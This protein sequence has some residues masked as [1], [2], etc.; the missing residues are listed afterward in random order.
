MLSQY[1]TKNP[2]YY[3]NPRLDIA[4]LLPES[5]EKVL[6]IGCGDGAT[7]AWL[8]A[9]NKCKYAAGVEYFPDAA[10][11]ARV[12]CDELYMGPVE[13]HIFQFS[14]ESFDLVLCLDVLEHLQDPWAV[15]NEIQ[16]VLRPGG[17][18]ICSL[19]NVRHKSVLLPLIFKNQWRYQESGIMDMTHLRFF[20][21][22]SAIDA[23]SNASFRVDKIIRKM[24]SFVSASGF[25]NILSMGMLAD[26]FAPQF[27]IKACK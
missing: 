3:G 27:L 9:T 14:N 4:P 20:T 19:P 21:T 2:R 6:E 12:S 25:A 8:R 7:L 17:I 22:K 10:K 18:L 11:K 26:F 23:I 24:P 5:T 13:A 16:R 15:L 1:S